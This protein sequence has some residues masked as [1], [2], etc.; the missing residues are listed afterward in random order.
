MGISTFNDA[1][2]FAISREK[3]AVAFYRDLQ[4]MARF[5]SQKE[6][7]GEFEDDGKR[8]CQTS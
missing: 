3:E 7:M 6:L 4:T 1:L 2:D 5:A 8:S